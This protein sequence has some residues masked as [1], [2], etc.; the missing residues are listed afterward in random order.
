MTDYPKRRRMEHLLHDDDLSP[1]VYRRWI[2][3]LAARGDRLVSVRLKDYLRALR[4]QQAQDDANGGECGGMEPPTPG[5]QPGG[6]QR[7]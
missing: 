1:G 3:E 4:A 7:D 6:S 5:V 2:Q